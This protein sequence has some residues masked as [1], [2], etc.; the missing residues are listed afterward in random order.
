MNGEGSSGMLKPLNEPKDKSNPKRDL[1]TSCIFCLGKFFR[2]PEIQN[3]PTLRLYVQNAK[4]LMC[5]QDLKYV[6]PEVI[7]HANK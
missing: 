3:L 4:K 2:G 1:I 6:S 5:L 7:Q